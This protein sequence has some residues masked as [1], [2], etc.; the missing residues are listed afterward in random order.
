MLLQFLWLVMSIIGMTRIK[1]TG[2]LTGD[3]PKDHQISKDFHFIQDNFG[4]SIPF[5]IMINYKEK[6]RLA[7]PTT[8]RKIEAI[9]K[10]YE[11]D[12]LFAKFISY[13]DFLKAVNMAYHDNDSTKFRLVTR[14]RD[15]SKLKKYLDNSMRLI[16]E[17]LGLRSMNWLIHQT[18]FL[19]FGRR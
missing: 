7:K 17:V 1:A 3:L 16:L 15:L 9:Q 2:N 6:S 13:V 14:S 18:M 10:H 8:L 4:G 19:E 12:T 5:E 11:K